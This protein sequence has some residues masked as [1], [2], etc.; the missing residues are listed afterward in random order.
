[1]TP[2]TETLAAMPKDTWASV[3]RHMRWVYRLDPYNPRPIPRE[4]LH[5]F[6]DPPPVAE[7]N[8]LKGAVT[9]LRSAAEVSQRA[10]I[11]EERKAR[12]REY[13]RLYMFNRR[14]SQREVQTQPCRKAEEMK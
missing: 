13:Q 11:L 5:L 4:I 9:K 14:R 1:M 12:R 6:R 2:L 10:Q 3:Q 8:A 7:W